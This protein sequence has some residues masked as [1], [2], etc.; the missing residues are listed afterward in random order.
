V[1][2]R[3]RLS[4]SFL[5][6][7]TLFA[8]NEGIQLWSAARRDAT[9]STLDRA[10]KRQVLMA[11][12]RGR[13]SDLH[14]QMSLLG[15]IDDEAP[16][17]AGGRA[18]LDGDVALVAGDI[19]ALV[20]MSDPADQRAAMELAQTFKDLAETWQRFYD[21]LGVEPG[22]ALAFQ[23]K[24]E[25][26]SRRVILELLPQL[27]Q[28]QK[29]RVQDAEAR[30]ASVS[31][32][33]REI[34]LGIFLG[35]M[36]IAGGVAFLLSRY[37]QNRLGELK[38]GAA[39]IGLM[40]LEHRIAVHSQDELGTV[41]AAFNDMAESLADARGKL[42]A[43]NGEL[44]TKNVEI[45]RQ[46]HKAESL[47]LNILPAQV[48][49]ELAL[50]GEVAP[51]YFEDVTILFTDFVGFTLATEKLAADEVVGVL[52]GYFKAFDE[53]AV[54]YGLEKLKTIGDSYF[55]AG[56][57]PVRS[58]SHPVDATL[59]AFE[60]I[61]EVEHRALPDGS[62]WA[63]RI[64]LHTGPVV[65]GVVGTKKFAFDVWGDTVNRASRVE[66]AGAPNRINI[67]S[68]MQR[69]IKDFFTTEN[70]GRLMTK[71]R[72]ELEMFSVGGV[73]PSLM[74]VPGVPP[75]AFAQR[76]QNYFDKELSA[77]PEFLVPAPD[78]EPDA[79]AT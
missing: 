55:C 16:A 53:I 27:E 46:R 65:A 56:G 73:L 40:N 29:L 12:V 51:R 70:R 8:V 17:P 61:H 77:F 78:L 7:L 76:Y 63:V 10:M 64:G 14:K 67:S 47:L 20:G 23:V 2:I 1:T 58:P 37:L 6:I 13:V 43:A 57:L 48:A 19:R 18:S 22:W 72:T 75:P 4:I 9:M 3:R 39:M 21:Y 44:T 66:S 28:L 52:H 11:A 25:P 33:T 42:Q 38:L 79:A 26:L 31:R 59:A 34:T 36:L 68:T 74:V 62:H 24:S 15:Q 69:R 35:S 41:A 45:E 71:E 54:R 30:F 49:A 50:R 32:V 60:M 5:T